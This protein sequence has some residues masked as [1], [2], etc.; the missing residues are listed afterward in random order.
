MQMPYG[1]VHRNEIEQA[2][3][4]AEHA[5]KPAGVRYVHYE[6]AKDWSG[7]WAVFFRILLSDSAT[8]GKRFE[9]ITERIRQMLRERLPEQV[10][11]L[12]HYWS[13][14]SESEAAELQDA[15]WK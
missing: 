10:F 4:E 8:R 9:Q 6:I 12:M 11:G 2:V 3:Q 14:R 5:F 7:D 1:V 15:A 13:F